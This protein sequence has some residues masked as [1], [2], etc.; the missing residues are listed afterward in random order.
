M[1]NKEIIPW[2]EREETERN[3]DIDHICDFVANGGSLVKYCVEK[4]VLFSDLSKWIKKQKYRRD[5]LREAKELHEELVRQHMT[6]M[7]LN[8]ARFDVKDVLTPG[9]KGLKPIEEWP[10]HARF[11]VEQLEFTEKDGVKFKFTPRM[12]AFDMAGK[13]AGLYKKKV[14]HDVGE[15]FSDLVEASMKGKGDDEPSD[16]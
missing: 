14:E 1:E 9:G 7:V 15:R 10:P 11:A 4:H 8:L 13:I 3:F 6:E 12:K 16:G 2:K 5:R